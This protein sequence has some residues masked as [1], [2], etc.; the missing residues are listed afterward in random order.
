MSFTPRSKS[1]IWVGRRY[2]MWDTMWWRRQGGE[3][4]YGE[5]VGGRTYGYGGNIMSSSNG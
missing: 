4:R 3:E 2:K 5:R 1:M